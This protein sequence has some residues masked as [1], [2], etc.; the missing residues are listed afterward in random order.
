MEVQL[1]ADISA[2]S[3]K[4]LFGL[5]LRQ[6]ALCVCG[7]AAA[8]FVGVKLAPVIGTGQIALPCAIAAA[9]FA[10]AALI[11]INGMTATQFAA[12][13]LRFFFSP[14]YL[15]FAS[16]NL[17]QSA[18]EKTLE[19]R[20]VSALTEDADAQTDLINKKVGRWKKETKKDGS[21]WLHCSCCGCAG[22]VQLDRGGGG[23]Y[24]GLDSCPVCEARM[25]LLG[26]ENFVEEAPA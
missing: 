14:R 12:A 8:V 26:F 13:V 16:E 1:N 11:P 21:V 19:Q 7:L 23:C 17:Y 25:L 5:T 24:D 9:P 2:Y 15:P 3:E 22:E 20:I 4:M 10:V 18:L 6:C